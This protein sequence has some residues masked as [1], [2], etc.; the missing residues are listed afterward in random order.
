[1]IR[2]GGKR[3]NGGTEY[4]PFVSNVWVESLK[5]V[6]RKETILQRGACG[7]SDREESRDEFTGS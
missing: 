6:M 3:T 7:V 1:M 2:V 4:Q 5:N